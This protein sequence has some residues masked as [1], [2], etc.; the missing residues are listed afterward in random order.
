MADQDPQVEA[1]ADADANTQLTDEIAKKYDPE[2]LLRMVSSRAGRGQSLEHDV[3]AKYERRFG[4]DLGHVRIMTGNFAEEFTKQRSAYAV[5]VGGTGM[6]LMGGSGDKGMHTRAG[7]ALLAH[8]LTHVA[9]QRR[10]LYNK[11]FDATHAQEHE[12][13]AEEVEAEIEAGGDGSGTSRINAAAAKKGAEDAKKEKTEKIIEKVM[14]MVAEAHRSN[15][16]RNSIQ[17]RP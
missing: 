12:Q 7:Q 15:W 11:D 6:I 10:G 14:D 4:V 2:R 8:E 3:R 9:Q 17:R 13:E 16:M 1:P 5:T